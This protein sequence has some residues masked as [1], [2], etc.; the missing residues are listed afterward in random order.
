MQRCLHA[1]SLG[2]R[3]QPMHPPPEP[4]LIILYLFRVDLYLFVPT[5]LART[6]AAQQRARC[7]R[8]TLGVELAG[9]QWE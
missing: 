2:M 8:H 9:M 3:P 4:Q 5:V 1:V 6:L 7:P